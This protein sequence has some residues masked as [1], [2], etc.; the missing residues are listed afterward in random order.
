M[1][2][3]GLL[4][5]GLLWSGSLPPRADA[6]PA[7]ISRHPAWPQGT[8]V[9]SFENLE[10]IILVEA[11]LH[12]TRVAD[13]T[14]ILALDTGAGYLALGHELAF[15][16]GLDDSVPEPNEI[17]FTA[18]PL[19][20]L[21]LGSLQIDQV[22]PVLGIDVEMIRQVT[23]RP[24]AGLLG[25]R[26]IGSRVV[27]I[28]YRAGQVALIPG[29]SERDE[30][31]QRAVP[32]DDIGSKSDGEPADSV[33]SSRAELRAVLSRNAVPVPFRLLGDGKM[34]VRGRVSIPFP[35]RFSPWLT[36]VVDTGSTKC[37]LFEE[38]LADFAAA[39]RPWPAL[40]GLQAP[41]LVGASS[42]RL[43]RVPYLELEAMGKELRRA[44]V[45]AAVMQSALSGVLS[46]AVGEPVHG[47]LGYSFLRHFCVTIDYPRH[48]LWLDP[49]PGGWDDRPYE[50][51]HVGL[52]LERRDGALRVIAVA[53]GSPADKAG[54]L[55]GDEVVAVDEEQV[56]GLD[57]L[58]VTRRLEGP[59]GT[60]TAITLRRG[61]VERTYSLVRRRLL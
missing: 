3:L 38:A 53:E 52:Q 56:S 21:E 29:S 28:D 42:A 18:R 5:L 40:R 35:P 6:A 12:G 34:L 17:E 27:Y 45:D 7:K 36:L 11:K 31:I 4:W 58:T 51:S 60:R 19:P 49:Q 26:V 2:L 44:G 25:Q 16:L 57:L 54:I 10:G 46:R 55:P 37:V 24:V 39:T 14:G 13:T 23:D 43:A 50:Y 15:A 32:K 30:S 20:R 33:A 1:R 9:L 61:S 22:S 48:V 59:P 8:E 47:L 41:T